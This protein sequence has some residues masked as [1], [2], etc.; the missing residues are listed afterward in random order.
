MFALRFLQL[1][2]TILTPRFR[3]SQTRLD[4]RGKSHVF[5]PSQNGASG[6]MCLEALT[7]AMEASTAT[8]SAPSFTIRSALGS[9]TTRTHARILTVTF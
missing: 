5:L 8:F 2:T 6:G 9:E 4:V 1:A 7:C 3:Y